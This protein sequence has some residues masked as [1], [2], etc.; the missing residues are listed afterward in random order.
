V[1]FILLAFVMSTLLSASC[2]GCD[3]ADVKL[4]ANE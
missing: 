1:S 3:I 4:F 2:G